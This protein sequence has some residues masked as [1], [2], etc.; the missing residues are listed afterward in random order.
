MRARGKKREIKKRKE[1]NYERKARINEKES[2]KG[3]RRESQEKER[4]DYIRVP[5]YSL[6]KLFIVL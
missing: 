3:K 4:K 6:F 1:M 2:E 5:V